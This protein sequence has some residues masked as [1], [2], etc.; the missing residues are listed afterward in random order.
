MQNRQHDEGIKLQE[1][2][3]EVVD[4]PLAERKLVSPPVFHPDV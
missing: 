1:R 2:R 4:V 3:T